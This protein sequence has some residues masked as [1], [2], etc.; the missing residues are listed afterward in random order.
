M[1]W[2]NKR[3]KKMDVWDV[4]LVKWSVAAVV[5]FIIGIWPAALNWVLSVNPWYFFV[6]F[7]VFAIRPIYK[8]YLK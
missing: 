7:I 5:L 4:G 8:V 3:I 6:A 2:W 1:N